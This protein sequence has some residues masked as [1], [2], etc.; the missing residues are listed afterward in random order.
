MARG[1]AVYYGLGA[2]PG[3]TSWL[4]VDYVRR[5]QWVFLNAHSIG[6]A[7]LQYLRRFDSLATISLANSS[8]TDDGLRHLLHLNG[9]KQVILTDTQ[10]TDDGVASLQTTFPACTIRR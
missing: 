9:L 4:P 6:D 5:P 1:G 8:V 2:A 7:D 10:V 3:I